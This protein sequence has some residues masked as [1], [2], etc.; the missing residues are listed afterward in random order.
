VWYCLADGSASSD[1]VY[2]YSPN[3]VTNNYYIYS[4]GNVTYSGAGHSGSN[5]FSSNEA[6]LF[7]NTMIAAYRTGN[8]APTVKITSDTTGDSKISCMYFHADYSA[9]AAGVF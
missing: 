1:N 9:A 6:K 2:G 8:T 5:N 3:D 4:V 7:V